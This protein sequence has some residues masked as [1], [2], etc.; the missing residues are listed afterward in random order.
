MTAASWPLTG[1]GLTLAMCG[2][3]LT[4]FNSITIEFSTQRFAVSSEHKQ[5]YALVSVYFHLYSI[6]SHELNAVPGKNTW[7]QQLEIKPDINLQGST[8]RTRSRRS[9]PRAQTL[10]PLHSLPRRQRPVQEVV[11]RL[12]VFPAIAS[13][14]LSSDLHPTPPPLWETNI[15]PHHRGNVSGKHD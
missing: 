3:L 13:P 10:Q 15:N 5:G 14:L 2:N 1:V 6:P 7:R 12:M 8:I 9:R 4:K 11:V